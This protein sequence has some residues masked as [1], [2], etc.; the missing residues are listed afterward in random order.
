MTRPALAALPSKSSGTSADLRAGHAMAVAFHSLSCAASHDP[1]LICQRRAPAR[2]H[3]LRPTK[4]RRLNALRCQRLLIGLGSALLDALERRRD[5]GMRR[6]G[7]RR[8]D[9]SVPPSEAVVPEECR[10]VLL[11]LPP[12]ALFEI[13]HETGIRQPYDLIMEYYIYDKIEITR[14][15]VHSV[16]H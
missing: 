12:R 10:L 16:A 8:W 9:R 1:L 14:Y 7:H 5:V 2:L 3:A 4:A 13:I 15:Y 11:G 6:R